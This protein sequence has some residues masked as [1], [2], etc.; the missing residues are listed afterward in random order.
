MMFWASGCRRVGG[1]RG[2]R[3]ALAF[4]AFWIALG[5]P[6]NLFAW[7]VAASQPAD[8]PS[9]AQSKQYDD[10]AM[11]DAD[12]GLL[13]LEVP[14]VVT[15]TRHEEPVAHLPYPI[16]VITQEDI[17]RSGARSVSDALRLAPGV[18]VADLNYGTP[19][20]GVRGFH[21][22]LNDTLL[23]LVDGRQIFDSY[24]GGTTWGGWP[25]QL[26]DIE[27]IEII[28]GPGG[29]TWGAN[30]VNGVINIITR[31]PRDQQGLSLTAGGGSRGTHKE[32]AGYGFTDGK[33]RMRVSGEFE[34][35]DGFLRG[36]DFGKG[37]D[38]Q[39]RQG[40]MSIHGVY[41][42][43]PD[44]SV[45]FSLGHGSM[46]GEND[47]PLMFGLQ[48][49]F[50]ARAQA[51]YALGKW[52]H[53]VA[54]DNALDLTFYVNDYWNVNGV[55]SVDVRYQQ[56]ALQLAHT[57]KPAENHTLTWG[58]DTRTDLADAS[59][60]DPYFLSEDFVASAIIGTYVQDV[61]RFAPKWS[62]S[63][64]GRVDYDFYGGFQPSGRAALGY[65]V[66]K[67]GL[68]YTSVSR[69]F[70]MPPAANRFLKLPI[71][72][73]LGAIVA[74]TGMKPE[75]LTAYEIGYR[76]R[77]G[78]RLETNV[79]LFWHDSNDVTAGEFGPGG[80]ALFQIYTTN[81]GSGALY[82]VELEAR[83]A[84]TEK[85]TLLGNFTFQEFDWQS[86]RPFFDT[87]YISPPRFKFMTGARYDLTD[88]VH[89]NGHLYFVDDVEAPNIRIP[90]F[91]HHI[92]DYVR[93]DLNA[94]F[95]FWK[96]RASLMVGVRNLTDS[97]HPEGASPSVTDAE[98]PRMVFAQ[99]RIKFD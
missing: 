93:L 21:G 58:V 72:N 38:D 39:Y 36:G 70:Q 17:R 45:T 87:T 71:A 98:I 25:F 6:S 62:L 51:S 47:V 20:V 29:V 89:L 43:G 79:N 35:S 30:A 64:G 94:E 34:G 52:R 97:H 80:P 2:C 53:K 69:A 33:L 37:V 1:E 42:A 57:L 46:L 9:A 14:V 60:A 75:T 24:F 19:A 84:L 68:L 23:V 31:D 3:C 54:E 56:I 55:R 78:K 41:D 99:V 32:H 82:G 88:D 12:I 74:E 28:R 44:D 67:D 66:T 59:N 11:D 22:F 10:M 15:A 86:K 50:Y 13:E 18:D 65:D 83:Y 90:I 95:D 7:Q 76:Q 61:W 77:F 63:L 49:H 16:S 26:D 40:R 73:N 5:W 85:L 4:L 48:D 27:R 91:A 8:G 81:R 96:D 92:P